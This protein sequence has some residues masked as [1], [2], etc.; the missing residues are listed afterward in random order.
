MV[1]LGDLTWFSC[2]PSAQPFP[3]N[4]VALLMSRNGN[5][6]D[7]PMV[8]EGGERRRRWWETR[9]LVGDEGAGGRRES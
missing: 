4:A 7:Y 8:R 9:E 6:N 3:A 2:D 1:S 5:E